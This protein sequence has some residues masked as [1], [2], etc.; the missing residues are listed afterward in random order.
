MPATKPTFLFASLRSLTTRLLLFAVLWW[1]LTE[2]ASPMSAWGIAGIAAAVGLSLHVFPAGHWNW[3][4]VPLIRFVPYFLWQSLLGG[5]DVAYR[6]LRPKAVVQPEVV[7]HGFSL[8]QEPARVFFLWV[9][10][11]LPGTAAMNLQEDKARVHVLDTNLAA[12]EK[13]EELEKRIA[14]LFGER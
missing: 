3:R 12:P 14:A 5:L 11:L 8:Q 6:A 2:G 1:V 4:L 13:L 7:S 9:V 10:S